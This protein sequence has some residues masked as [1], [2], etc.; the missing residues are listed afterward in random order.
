MNGGGSKIALDTTN[1][2]IRIA[3]WQPETYV[4]EKTAVGNR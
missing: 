3:S 2:G 4:V 1:G